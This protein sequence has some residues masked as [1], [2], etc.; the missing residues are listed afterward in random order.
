MNL[1]RPSEAK[2]TPELTSQV[3]HVL[4]KY[5]AKLEQGIP[6]HPEEL[7]AQHP[8]L[9]E[10][11]RAYLAS[12][13]FLHRAALSLHSAA[14]SGGAAPGGDSP[15][16]GQLG[17]FRIR[18]EIAHGGMGEIYEAVQERLHRRVALKIIRRGQVSPEARA[19]FLR[20]QQVLARLH[21]T[22]IVPIHTA[23]AV[24]QG[25]SLA[26]LGADHVTVTNVGDRR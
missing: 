16:L 2:F 6:P 7:L 3:M 9:A 20:E 10:P 25:G 14:K 1:P 18:R 5:L 13:E 21:Q 23:G 24:H 4:E 11:L 26:L 12:L 17:D 15:K 22:H 8:D 19:R